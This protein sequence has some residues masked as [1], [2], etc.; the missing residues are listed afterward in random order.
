MIVWWC[1]MMFDE[2]LLMTQWWL[3]GQWSG[4]IDVI[5]R[6]SILALFIPGNH[7]AELHWLMLWWWIDEVWWCLMMNW[8]WLMMID[9]VWWWFDDEMM[10]TWGSMEWYHG[11]DIEIKRFNF[12]HS[13]KSPCRPPLVDGLM[14][15]W[16]CLML[17]DDGLMVFDDV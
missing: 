5:S 9:D 10:M 1:L 4:T 11:C 2:C 6:L 3:E 8:W 14:M 12:V 7:H 17:F 15:N 16:W 13:R